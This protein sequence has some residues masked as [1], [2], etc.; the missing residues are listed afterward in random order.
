MTFPKIPL[1]CYTFS[2]SQ[3]PNFILAPDFFQKSDLS[4]AEPR[5][6]LDLPLEGGKR[7]I[8]GSAL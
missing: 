4:N 3:I 6:G 5:A 2:C 7:M 8:K 1:L